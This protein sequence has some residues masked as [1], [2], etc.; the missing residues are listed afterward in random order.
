MN[1]PD[2][3][4]LTIDAMI[5]NIDKGLTKIPQFQR[6]FVWSREKS[7]KLIDSLV[8]GYPI[9]TFI[10]WQTKET[11]R[12]VREVGHLKLPQTPEGQF[13]QYVLDGQQRMTSVYACIKG[14]TLHREGKVIDYKDIW[15]DLEAD[16]ESEIVCINGVED[17]SIRYVRVRDLF[18]GSFTLI[19]KYPA[20]LHPKMQMYRD[21]LKG[22]LFSSILIKEVEIEVATDIFTRI[23]TTGKYLTLFEIMVAKTFSDKS[24]FDL[25]EKYEDLQKELVSV[26]FGTL[27]PLIILQVV[28][29]ILRKDCSTKTIL[30]LPRTEFIATWPQAI[31]ALKSAVD[32]LRLQ[33]RVPASELLPFNPA[34]V[35]IAYFFHLNVHAP[36]GQVQKLLNDLFWRISLGGR[37]SGSV[38]T[39]MAQDLRRVDKIYAGEHPDYDWPV[40]NTYD[41]ISENGYFSASRSYIKGLLCILVAQRPLSFDTNS[42]V[43]VRNDGTYIR[44]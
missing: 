13:T 19:S 31:S 7:A 37:Y 23:N 2:P 44:A 28:S 10:I 39:K 32:Y 3:Q 42:D 22:F 33:I 16:G 24:K 1:R 6:E 12:S 4:A 25:L 30:S 35:I 43:S 8:K 38:E 5:S 26:Q 11:L 17:G 41:F 34:V 9:G 18:E 36:T 15:V 14:A 21:Q 20:N 29:S 27:P 40:E